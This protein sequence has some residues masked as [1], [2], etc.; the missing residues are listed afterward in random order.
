MAETKLYSKNASA[1][2]AADHLCVNATTF[3]SYLNK[4]IIERQPRHKGYDLDLIR[5]QRFKYLENLAAGRSG[6]DGGQALSRQRARLAQA[7][8]VRE[9]MKTATLTGHL[10]S[11]EAVGRIL[12]REFRNIRERFLSMPGAQS[13]RL[14]PYTPKDRAEIFNILR[15][16]V[17]EALNDVADGKT[18][19]SAAANGKTQWLNAE[20]IADDKEAVE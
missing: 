20:P 8:A 2:A 3:S 11:T 17:Y 18:I 16:V 9:E 19:A 7:Q 12:D 1:K 6:D 15:D 5:A 10:V 13:D 14:T 4:G